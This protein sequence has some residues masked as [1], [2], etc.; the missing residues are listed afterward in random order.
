MRSAWACV[1]IASPTGPTLRS[2]Q[3]SRRSVWTS[4]KAV[5]T[6]S[7]PPPSRTTS[8]LDSTPAADVD[9]WSQNPS[10]NGRTR[11]SGA[12]TVSPSAAATPNASR[13]GSARTIARIL[14][15]G[16]GTLAAPDERH[17]R[18]EDRQ[19][20]HVRV[21]RQAGHVQHRARDV[22]DVDARLGREPPVRLGHARGHLLGQLGG[23]VADVDLAAGDV[24]LP[25]VERRALGQPGDRVL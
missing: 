23:G 15:N 14:H 3:S 11:R 22:L 19:E 5:S 4:V 9:T 25:A 2:A 13:S 10:F 17:L 7:A 8:P 12:S 20:L 1:T 6:S 16:R 21:E 18:R 24:V